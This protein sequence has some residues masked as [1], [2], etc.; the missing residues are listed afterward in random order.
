MLDHLKVKHFHHSGRKV[1]Y[2]EFFFLF[3]NALRKKRRYRRSD[4]IFLCCNFS[5]NI[6]NIIQLQKIFE[7]FDWH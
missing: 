1:I 3:S 4:F 5:I 6:S 2:V 7:A